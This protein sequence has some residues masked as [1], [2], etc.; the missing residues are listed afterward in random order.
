MNS[1]FRLYPIEIH[2]LGDRGSSEVTAAGRGNATLRAELASKSLD[3]QRLQAAHHE[4]T[5]AKD[6]VHRRELAGMKER[7]RRQG[8]TLTNTSIA[9]RN[10]CK[11]LNDLRHA[12]L[13]LWKDSEKKARS[14]NT[15]RQQQQAEHRKATA[16]KEAKER[17]L[18]T[19]LTGLRKEAE[20][21]RKA[22]KEL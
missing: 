11:E 7:L 14:F 13:A 15:Q 1:P 9:L 19:K 16:A 20:V 10:R 5:E 8:E 6:S 12:N 4:E 21:T 3:L 18:E 17:E 22:L 2:D